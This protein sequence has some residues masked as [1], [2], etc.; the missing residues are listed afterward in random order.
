MINN[1]LKT[2]PTG[3]PG[4]YCMFDLDGNP[5]YAGQS[6][7]LRNRLRQHFIRQDS[8]VVS[9]G[10]LDIWDIASVEWWGTTNTDI[11]ENALLSHYRPYLNFNREI[12]SPMQQ[13]PLS[14]E[15]PDGELQLLTEEELVFRSDPY[16]RSKQKLEH[17]LRMIDKIKIAGHSEETKKTL[18]EH[19]R[20]LKENISDFLGV[21]NPNQQHDL[22]DWNDS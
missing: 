20:I 10:R 8:S 16:Q 11:A 15:N 3:T 22:T 6:G 19:Q 17:L 4:V 2:I 7:D 12:S 14:I 1:E 13:T 21:A 18:Y 5:A 9:Y